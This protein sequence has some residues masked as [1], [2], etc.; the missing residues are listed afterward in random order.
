MINN[1]R[2]GLRSAIIVFICIVGII[3]IIGSGT[4][5]RSRR[6][7]NRVTYSRAHRV[8][9]IITQ[10]S[11]AIVNFDGKPIGT[12]PHNFRF[13][14]T[15]A[16]SGYHRDEERNH[17]IR[18]TKDGYEP[19]ELSFSIKD[20]NLK[21]LPNPIILKSLFDESVS[22]TGSAGLLKR[23]TTGGPTEHVLDLSPDQNW[24]LIQVNEKGPQASTNSVLQKLNLINGS[25]VLLSPKESSNKYA[26]WHPSGSSI[27]FV[28][29]RL[30]TPT[31][32]ESLGISGEVGVRFI[33]QPSLGEARSP[34]VSP[35]GDDIAFS[36]GQHKE[37]LTLAIVSK[38]GSN[39]RIFGKGFDPS[40]SPNGKTLL[41]VRRVGAHDQI[42]RMDPKS[43]TNLV[44]LSSMA[45]ND[46]LPL[47]S[48]SG[49]YVAFISDRIDGKM[50]I[51]LM[52]ING[53]NVTQL[54]DGNFSVKSIAWGKNGFIYFSAN[55]GG[56]WD[57][58]RLRPTG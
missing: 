32:V 16:S 35:E 2:P 7:T 34:N 12:S 26:V 30:G 56:N 1:Y 57:I 38:D 4:S 48:P 33:T 55:A 28:S 9:D 23:L 44:Q 46:R 41:F 45:C 10:P 21:N 6:N 5:N 25:R 49:H 17:T 3:T 40:W 14:F 43:G 51:Y 18:I 39:L 50:H 29:N 37:G 20:G 22:I 52:D 36:I 11:N 31:L 8:I 19:F 27:I 13:N 15:E 47:F 24:L 42:F 54:T 58:W 53:Q